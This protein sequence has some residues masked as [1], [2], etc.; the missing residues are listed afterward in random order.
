LHTGHCCCNRALLLHTVS[1]FSNA[2]VNLYRACR[3]GKQA[4]WSS[5]PN[6]QT[7]SDQET[8]PAAI[9]RPTRR[10]FGARRR[11]RAGA[12]VCAF[13]CVRA[14]CHADLQR[15]LLRAEE[16]RQ[17]VLFRH[18]GG[19]VALAEPKRR[20][21]AAIG[22]AARSVGPRAWIR[23]LLA[24]RN[25]TTA[26]CLSVRL[27]ACLFLCSVWQIWA[28]ARVDRHLRHELRQNPVAL[29][30]AP[31]LRVARTRAHARTR[32]LKP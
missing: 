1:W 27:L 19:V 28:R 31:A 8:A 15:D 17:L 5:I 14:A 24:L 6:K 26:A 23:P 16:R 11:C 7:K 18:V 4:S 22:R 29:E 13:V 21:S 3:A 20:R 2:N 32:W 9:R 10:R 30:P 12:F 25:A